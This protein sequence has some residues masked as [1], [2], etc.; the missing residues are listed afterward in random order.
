M[1][2]QNDPQQANAE[3]PR[4]SGSGEEL[5]SDQISYVREAFKWQYNLIGLGGLVAFAL[6]SASALPLVLGAGLEL[7]YLSIIPRNSR[8]QRLVRSWKYAEEKSRRETKLN[9]LFLELPPSLRARY[10]ALND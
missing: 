8:F 10:T 3:L 1:F 4:T 6:L 5:G 9:A 7:I 2:G